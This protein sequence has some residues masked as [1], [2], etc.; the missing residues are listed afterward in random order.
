MKSPMDWQER[1][2]RIAGE[3]LDPREAAEIIEELRRQIKNAAI[4]S[5]IEEFLSGRRKKLSDRARDT[6]RLVA[7]GIIM[8]R[9][10]R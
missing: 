8:K 6:L 5:E 1:G 2:I 3:V 4:L 7:L 9:P 10:K